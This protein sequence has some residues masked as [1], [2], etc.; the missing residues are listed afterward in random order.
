MGIMKFLRKRWFWLT[1]IALLVV[2][3]L[4]LF[5]PPVQ[6]QIALFYL[7]KNFDF[8]SMD[9]LSIGSRSINVD[10]LNLEK[11]SYAFRV[12]SLKIKWSLWSLLS[13]KK[14]RHR[15]YPG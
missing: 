3:F 5:L 11:G 6:R 4:S 2:A 15:R 8:V 12:K 10:M 9:R 7:G 13:K 14:N 1:T